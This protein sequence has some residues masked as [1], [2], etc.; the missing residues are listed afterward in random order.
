[1]TFISILDHIVTN[2][3]NKQSLPPPTSSNRQHPFKYLANASVN[4]YSPT[5]M[6]RLK[7]KDID[8]SRLKKLRK[9]LWRK[10][11]KYFIKQYLADSET[12]ENA[13]VGILSNLQSAV[14]S[15]DS[16]VSFLSYCEYCKQNDKIGT[17]TT[18]FKINTCQSSSSSSSS[19]DY[20]MFI[21]IQPTSQHYIQQQLLMHFFLSQIKDKKEKEANLSIFE[22]NETNN[23][24][25]TS[26]TTSSFIENK[27][28]VMEVIGRCRPKKSSVNRQCLNDLIALTAMFVKKSNTSLHL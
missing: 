15:G 25:S 21:L 14:I 9:Y 12:E 19:D 10:P 1:M 24:Q 16:A 26:P 3:I 2:N 28:L 20:H 7:V 18:S 13:L 5:N 8:I 22:S 17:I 11:L 6:N 27:K 23:S 4:I